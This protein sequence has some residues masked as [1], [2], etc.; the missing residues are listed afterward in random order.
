MRVLDKFLNIQQLI[1]SRNQLEGYTDLSVFYAAHSEV[2][3]PRI[4]TTS[5]HCESFGP[6]LHYNLAEDRNQSF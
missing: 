2:L 3:M 1:D 6:G 5:S 4:F